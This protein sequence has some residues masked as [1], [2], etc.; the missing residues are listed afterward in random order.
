MSIT[1]DPEVVDAYVDA[2][3]WGHD[4]P[5]DLIR[6]NAAERPGD[7]AYISWSRASGE[8]DNTL[9]SIDRTT[10]AGYDRLSDQVAAAL[11]AAGLDRG[12]RVAVI[13]PD[14]AAVH[15]SFTG[16]DKAGV[17]VMG[18]G[19]RAGPAEIS[20]LLSK[21]GAT[22]VITGIEHQG[23]PAAGAVAEL[24]RDLPSLA[25]HITVDGLGQGFDH[26]SQRPSRPRTRGRSRLY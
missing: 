21:S 5:T 22:A 17:V 18:I 11:L 8:A 16:A 12:D 15:A 24:R 19:H 4:T 1:A 6:R 25:H 26:R 13:L 7:V 14:S 2:G 20:H 10:W 9:G 23:R 3:W